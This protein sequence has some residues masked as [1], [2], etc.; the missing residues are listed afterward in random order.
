M[1]SRRTFIATGLTIPLVFA[2]SAAFAQNPN[3]G[4][5]FRV[6][7]LGTGT[8]VPS[9]KRF[10]PSTLIQVGGETFLFDCGRGATQRLWQLGIRFS[11]VSA[12][13]LT[14]LHSDHIV[15]IPDLWATGW[16]NQAWGGRREPMAVYGPVGTRDMMENMRKAFHWDIQARNKEQNLPLKGIEVAASE[17]TEG[18][19]VER[20]GVKVM[21]FNV[22]HGHANDPAFGFRIEYGGRAVVISGDANPNDNLVRNAQNADLYIQQVVMGFNTGP[23]GA[24]GRRTDPEEAGILFTQT[25]PRLAAYSH[26]AL[27]GAHGRGVPSEQDLIDATRKTYAGPLVVGEDLMSFRVGMKD[28][29]Y[30]LHQ[31]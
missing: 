7:L 14:H 27:F 29:S 22:D 2:T 23:G 25:K 1:P 28:V 16:L 19:V 15:G 21:A 31:P 30:K 24:R 13:F 26:I 8:P 17:F 5:D 6:T 18:V 11:T 9:V 10:G 3:D 4:D 12:L 20:N